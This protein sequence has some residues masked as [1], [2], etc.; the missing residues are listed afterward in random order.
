MQATGELHHIQTDSQALRIVSSVI[1]LHRILYPLWSS[2]STEF[3]SGTLLFLMKVVEHVYSARE[4]VYVRNYGA[5]EVA[6]RVLE[7]LMG[8]SRAKMEMCVEQGYVHF[9]TRMVKGQHLLIRE[10]ID[11]NVENI[12]LIHSYHLEAEY[13]L[14]TYHAFLSG[15]A[16]TGQ[17]HQ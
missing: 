11:K 13:R 17:D 9:Y 7:M 1:N 4:G 2:A 6:P 16:S 8:V 3:V 10:Y 5:S 14:I 15:A 12:H